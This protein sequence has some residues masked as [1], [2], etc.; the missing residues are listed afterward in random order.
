M[1]D[2]GHGND[3]DTLP[4]SLLDTQL[5]LTDGRARGYARIINVRA[6]GWEKR[7]DRLA[8]LLARHN[9]TT[10]LLLLL[11]A[12]AEKLVEDLE[13]DDPRRGKVRLCVALAQQ[14]HMPRQ[15][16]SLARLAEWFTKPWSN[17]RTA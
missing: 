14:H 7:T 15:R 1:A 8:E 3:D 2:E 13:A 10:A 9:N 16:C 12:T 6:E 5:A 17:R 4:A 11:T